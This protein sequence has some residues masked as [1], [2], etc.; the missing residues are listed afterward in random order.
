MTAEHAA[1]PDAAPGGTSATGHVE[2]IFLAP[3]AEAPP[4]PVSTA[5]AQAGKGLVGDRYGA[6]VGTY[7]GR[8]GPGRQLTFI[9][10]EAVEALTR[11]TGIALE[12]GVH[13]RNVVTR[14]TDLEALIGKRFRVGSVECVGVRPC[15][16]CAHLE[17]LTQAGVL[18]GLVNRGGLRADVTASGRLAVGDT[19]V[20]LGDA[21]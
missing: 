9:A 12:P 19:L 20:V 8:P 3:V 5:E 21:G 6:A 16:P 18:K 17:G 14:D 7:S 1:G 2:A 10:A 4:V 11:E 15:T 13:R